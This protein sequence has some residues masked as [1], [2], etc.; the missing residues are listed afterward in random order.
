MLRRWAGGAALPF[1]V[2]ARLEAAAGGAARGLQV[3]LQAA[4]AAATDERTPHVD[5]LFAAR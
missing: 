5:A 2:F 4:R 3:A 1:A